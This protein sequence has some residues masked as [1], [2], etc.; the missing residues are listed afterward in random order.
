[1]STKTIA[2]ESSVYERLAREKRQSESFTRVV[3]RLLDTASAAH[4][5]GAI[6]NELSRM[7]ALPAHD[8]ER[9]LAVIRENRA[10]EEWAGHDLR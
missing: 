10:T 9:M 1:M 7:S 6:A 8:A 2:L 4:T 3:S 5:G